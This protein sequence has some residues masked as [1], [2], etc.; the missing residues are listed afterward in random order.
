MVL[1]LVVRNC[2]LESSCQQD[3][4]RKGKNRFPKFKGQALVLWADNNPATTNQE[5]LPPEFSEPVLTTR[6]LLAFLLR[7][8]R[9]EF[10][11]LRG[12]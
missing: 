7:P 6:T 3:R 11:P 9:P 1:G 2:T 12:F 4:T 5:G 8:Q 10:V